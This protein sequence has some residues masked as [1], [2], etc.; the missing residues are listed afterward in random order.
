MLLVLG[1]C[2]PLWEVMLGAMRLG[3]VVIPATPQLSAADL[4]DR[5]TRGDAK[6]L[7]AA[8]ADAEK[9]GRPRPGAREDPG[10]R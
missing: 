8:A 1:N 6:L 5:V 9:F 3:A 7:V 2:V 10:R 4:D